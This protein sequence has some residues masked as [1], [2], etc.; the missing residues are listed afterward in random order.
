M[1]SRVIVIFVLILFS[2]LYA[3]QDDDPKKQKIQISKGLFVVRGN[4]SFL[5][6]ISYFDALSAPRDILEAD[7]SFLR[8]RRFN[9]I[10]IWASWYDEFQPK[11][12]SVIRK[13]G[14]LNPD[15]VERLKRVLNATKSKN[16]LVILVFSRDALPGITFNNYKSGIRKVASILKPYRFLLFDVQNETN[17]CGVTD[18]N[19]TG[20]L[21][22]SQVSAIRTAVKQ[23]DSQRLVTASRNQDGFIPGKDDYVTFRI[24]GNVDFIATHRPSRT[25]DGNWANLTDDEAQSIRAVVGPKIPI[26][27]DEPN[28]CGNNM[29][30][31]SA[32]ESNYFVTAAKNAKKSGAAGWIFH[33]KAG[34]HLSRRPLSSQLVPIEK[35]AIDRI[36]QAIGM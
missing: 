17:H 28:R 23:V 36:A 20:H 11:A 27:F 16:L 5:L 18:V 25:K 34:F 10:R 4:P 26:L 13:N 2:P 3:I 14:T 24:I 32:S 1:I 30:C 31:V 15:G 21:T 29:E 6:G 33:T 22:L 35:S 9:T 12:S 7:L 8:V 19:C